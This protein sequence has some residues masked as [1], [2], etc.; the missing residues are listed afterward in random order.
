MKKRKLIIVIIAAIIF[1]AVAVFLFIL[2]VPNRVHLVA[3]EKS[4]SSSFA[5]GLQ[6]VM[7]T[8]KNNSIRTIYY[9]AAFRLEKWDEDSG[10]W[11]FYDD[12]PNESLRID[13]GLRY[14]YP[15]S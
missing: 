8:M 7:F 3:K 10:I 1:A 2:D 15:F 11:V 5:S 9:G 13:L 4:V 12:K 14:V 6:F